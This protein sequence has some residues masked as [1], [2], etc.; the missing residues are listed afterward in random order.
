MI[1]SP[2]GSRRSP[3]PK[4]ISKREGVKVNSNPV[5][6]HPSTSKNVTPGKSPLND[7]KHDQVP[8]RKPEMTEGFRDLL[9]CEVEK[10]EKSLTAKLVSLV[11]TKD[12][13]ISN[14]KTKINQLEQKRRLLKSRGNHGVSTEKL[15]KEKEFLQEN[16]KKLKCV[17]IPLKKKLEEQ[18]AD[19]KDHEEKKKEMEKMFKTEVDVMKNKLSEEGKRLQ[20]KEEQHKK[21]LL[22]LEKKHASDMNSKEIEL[23]NIKKQLAD[24][25]EEGERSKENFKLLQSDNKSLIDKMKN[26]EEDLKDQSNSVESLKGKLRDVESSLGAY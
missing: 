19:L 21:K 7:V 8:K 24:T 6:S 9:K 4:L 15:L 17:V 11:K 2:R 25:T 1:R 12:S 23:K 20:E 18:Q 3:M 22:D 13:E 5:A 14:L 26:L 16:F 10:I